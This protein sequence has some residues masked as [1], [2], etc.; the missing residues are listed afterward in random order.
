MSTRTQALIDKGEVKQAI[1]E[2]DGI[3]ALLLEASRHNGIAG[4]GIEA[5]ARYIESLTSRLEDA[6][7]TVGWRS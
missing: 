7:D 3:A 4:H 1:R 2:L 5:A 6:L